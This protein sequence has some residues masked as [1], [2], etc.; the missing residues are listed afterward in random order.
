MK[1][2]FALLLCFALA[3]VISCADKS[4]DLTDDSSYTKDSGKENSSGVSSDES[5]SNNN[6]AVNQYRP[7]YDY[8]TC[9]ELRGEVLA[10]LFF[11][12]DFESKWMPDEISRFTTNE[13]MPALHFIERS[14][15]QRGIDLHFSTDTNYGI[16]YDDDVIQSIH[17][18]GLVTI[19]TL[20]QAANSLYYSSDTEFIAQM[21]QIHQVDEVVCF[22][23][24]NKDGTAYAV[25]PKKGSDI[26]V[27]EH[28][29]LFARDYKTQEN[30]KAG[31]MASVTAHEM[32]H[33]FG[34]ED[35]YTPQSRKRLAEKHMPDD[36]MTRTPYDIFDAKFSDVTA[37]FIGWTDNIPNIITEEEW[38]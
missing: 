23:I 7:D 4:S 36:I 30:M 15:D 9:K 34:A 33:L 20:Y 27:E 13:V 18:S 28:C 11:M 31:A 8:G 22:T 32:L 25:N 35:Y 24:F 14:A 17:D 16:T 5:S 38:N 1:K 2:I 3:F 26:D 10:V 21:K 37:F 29:I 12:D 6:L 19:D